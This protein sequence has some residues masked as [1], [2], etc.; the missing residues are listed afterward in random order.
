MQ[1]L[2]SYNNPRQKQ[3]EIERELRYATRPKQ[4]VLLLIYINIDI[5]STLWPCVVDKFI[6]RSLNSSVVCEICSLVAKYDI[7]T[8]LFLFLLYF[9]K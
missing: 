5:A 4:S 9:H 2:S 6:K 8:D 1:P 7:Y 3:E